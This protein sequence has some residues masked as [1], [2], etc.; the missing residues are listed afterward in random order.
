MEETQVTSEDKV[1]SITDPETFFLTAINANKALE[2]FL[3]PRAD[4]EA[5]KLAMYKNISIDGYS[6]LESLPKD[7]SRS[8][9]LNTINTY[10][11]ASGIRSDLVIDS[12]KTLYNIN[13]DIKKK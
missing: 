4:N 3:G 9:T 8:V 6:T 1:A 2:E 10:L 5:G 13:Q 7:I 12:L 11:L